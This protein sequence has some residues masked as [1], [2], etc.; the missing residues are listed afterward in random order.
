MQRFRKLKTKSTLLFEE[1]VPL[2]R[3]LFFVVQ[4][5]LSTLLKTLKT[6]IP[7]VPAMDEYP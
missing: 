6:I 5:Q 3:D 7:R 4:N 2:K 1:K